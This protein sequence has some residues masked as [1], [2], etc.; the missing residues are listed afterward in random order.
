M[1]RPIAPFAW[2]RVPGIRFFERQLN[3]MT[4]SLRPIGVGARKA[5]HRPLAQLSAQIDA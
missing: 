5:S 1:V 4:Q 3:A 2:R